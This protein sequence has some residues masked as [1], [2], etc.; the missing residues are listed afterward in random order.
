MKIELIQTKEPDGDW[1]KIRIDDSTQQ[2]ISINPGKEEEALKRAND[3]YD[4]YKEC[5]GKFKTIKSEV[6]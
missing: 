4:F 6:I 5:K 1:Y 3:I 2:C